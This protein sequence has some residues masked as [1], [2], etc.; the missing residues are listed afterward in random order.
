MRYPRVVT[1]IESKTVVTR[2]WGH[3]I[4]GSYY[5]I[6]K[7]RKFWKWMVVMV[8]QQCKYN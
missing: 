8:A 6:E 2:N 3:D 4:T 1:F 5:L 7:M